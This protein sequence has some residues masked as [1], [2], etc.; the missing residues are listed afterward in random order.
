MRGVNVYIVVHKSVGN[1]QGVR[2]GGVESVEGGGVGE[3][4]MGG[5]VSC[6]GSFEEYV[7][8]EYTLLVIHSP[9]NAAPVMFFFFPS[10]LSSGVS[11][12]LMVPSPYGDFRPTCSKRNTIAYDM[13]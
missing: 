6:S 11:N 12:I 1:S 4:E 13:I 2:S 10:L 8:E 9:I 5:E 7:L 3:G